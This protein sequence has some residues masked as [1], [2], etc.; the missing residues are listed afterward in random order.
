MIT[1]MRNKT[2]ATPDQSSAKKTP[3]S[4][5][6]PPI[7]LKSI[8]IAS[9]C[10]QAR[11]HSDNGYRVYPPKVRR[12]KRKA[13]S[14]SRQWK[15]H[16]CVKSSLCSR[17]FLVLGG[18]VV[19]FRNWLRQCVYAD[20]AVVVGDSV[21]AVVVVGFLL[22]PHAIAVKARVEHGISHAHHDVWVGA[23]HDPRLDGTVVSFQKAGTHQMHV[24]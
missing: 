10:R 1:I 17:A 20:V 14:C 4:N 7:R 15:K 11:K 2:P 21:D 24:F 5:R 3:L 19:Y 23:R 18:G 6:F 12:R 9:C 22:Q 13:S 16:Q 8:H